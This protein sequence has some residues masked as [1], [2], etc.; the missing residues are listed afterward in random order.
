MGVLTSAL[1]T[2]GDSDTVAKLEDCATG[3]PS[4]VASHFA[5][6]SPN[7][8]GKHIG[9]VQQALKQVQTKHPELDIPK[10]DVNDVYD[11][12]FADA[13]KA[14][15]KARRIVNYANAIDDI[16]G[17]NTI[18]SLDKEMPGGG[19]EPKKK[20]A[21]AAH[22]RPILPPGAPGPTGDEARYLAEV[23]E[24]HDTRESWDKFR[25]GVR[26]NLV[27]NP[28][29]ARV[30]TFLNKIEKDA[31]ALPGGVPVLKQSVVFGN[32]AVGI[33]ADSTDQ[34]ATPVARGSRISTSSS[35]DDRPVILFGDNGG[36]LVLG[37]S[38]LLV[39]LGERHEPERP[40]A[41]TVTDYGNL[42]K[43]MGGLAGKEPAPK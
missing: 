11:Q 8:T 32:A 27:G 24:K 23:H 3:S 43:F 30:E 19:V 10:F 7:R 28:N 15:K 41:T 17:V 21:N 20:K 6:N 33:N 35:N 2:T 16:V 9:K 36:S 38:S 29:A 22:A 39:V 12:N 14:Y 34:D 40:R 37:P 4:E 26:A 1:F 5:Q 42:K 25:A 31:E 13:V 18:K